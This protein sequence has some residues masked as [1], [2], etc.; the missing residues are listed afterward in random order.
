MGYDPLS[1]LQGISGFVH[2]VETG[3][4][5]AAGMRMGLSKSAVGKSVARL[6]QRLG[7]KLLTRTTRQLSL[8]E[9]GQVYYASCLKVLDELNSTEA[10]LASRHRDV[11]GRLRI[12]LPL[13]F[14]RLWVMPVLHDI[15]R[16]H[17]KLMLDVTFTDRLV[18]LVDEGI[19]LVVRVGDPGDSA[20]L[21]GRRIG[22]QRWML[23]AS[24]AYIAANGL[25]TTIKD[26]ERH[27]CIIFMRNGRATPWMLSDDDGNVVEARVKP[28]HVIRHG[29]ALREAVLSGL[30]IGYMSTWLIADHLRQKQL[31]PVLMTAP[32]SEA[33]IHV[34][35]HGSRA[36]APKIRVV[37]DALVQAFQPV[38]PWDEI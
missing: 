17:P 2:T 1:H 5:T 31:L 7:V 8:T 28:R 13:S 4:F 12:N 36:P 22:T 38:S 26:L 23:C 24:P 3:S 6:E 37:V 29:E 18:D 19:D 11:S 25:P 33:P 34:L 32:V 14:G 15:A 20:S 27:Q 10:L 30:G 21:I 9:E 35:W 16:R